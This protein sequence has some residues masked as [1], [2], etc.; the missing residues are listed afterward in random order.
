MSAAETDAVIARLIKEQQELGPTA[1]SDY[2]L[3]V[4]AMLA[5]HSPEPVTFLLD[6]ADERL[7]K[8]GADA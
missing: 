7:E 5:T 4:L 8:L 3:V 1:F 6:R 2:T